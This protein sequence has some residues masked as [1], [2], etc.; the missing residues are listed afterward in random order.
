[1]RIPRFILRSFG[2]N[3]QSVDKLI[4][5]ILSQRHVRY[6]TSPSYFIK[7]TILNFNLQFSANDSPRHQ[8]LHKHSCVDQDFFSLNSL[9]GWGQFVLM[10]FSWQLVKLP[11]Y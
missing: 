3:C 11:R 1:M 8:S 7:N 9:V 5:S 2:N 4:P 10:N 6:H